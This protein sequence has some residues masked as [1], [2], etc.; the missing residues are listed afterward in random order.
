M[1]ITKTLLKRKGACRI[2]LALFASYY[3]KGVVVTRELCLKHAHEFNWSWAAYNLL[4]APARKAFEEATAPAREAC[5]EVTA[6]ALKA[7]DEATALAF[8]DAAALD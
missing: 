1:K 8:A 3:P 5:D 7:Y 2:Q 4:S 6:L